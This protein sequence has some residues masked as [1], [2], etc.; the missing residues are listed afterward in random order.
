MVYL[1]SLSS[2]IYY[3]YYH[4]VTYL[5]PLLFS[6][7][8]IKDK[9]SISYLCSLNSYNSY[10]VTSLRYLAGDPAHISPY[11]TVEL[12]GSTDPA[13]TTPLTTDYLTVDPIPMNES[14]VT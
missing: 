14:D 13:A 3:Y 12:G 11:P 4:Y 10:G 2:K 7:A 5:N 6:S 9:S 8:W 1:S